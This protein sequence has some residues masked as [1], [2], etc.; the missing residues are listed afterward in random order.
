MRLKG[1]Q[2]RELHGELWGDSAGTRG[3]RSSISNRA[4]TTKSHLPV[5]NEKLKELFFFFLLSLL[6]KY[7]HAVNICK[8]LARANSTCCNKKARLVTAVGFL[9]SEITVR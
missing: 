5:Y 4:H 3:G 6:V 2:Q 8:P 1:I 7:S 9:P